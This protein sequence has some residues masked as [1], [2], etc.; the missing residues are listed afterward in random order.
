MATDA[1][2]LERMA[3]ESPDECFLK[4]SGILKLTCAIRHLESENKR[5]SAELE[6]LQTKCEQLRAELRDANTQIQEFIYPNNWDGS[7]TVGPG[8]GCITSN[9]YEP[10]STLRLRIDVIGDYWDEAQTDKVC[11][12][13]AGRLNNYQKLCA[14]LEALKAVE[15]VAYVR[16]GALY[17]RAGYASDADADLYTGPQLPQIMEGWKLVPIELA[18]SMLAACKGAAWMY[19][20]IAYKAMLEAAPQPEPHTPQTISSTGDQ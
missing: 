5:L 15:P 4:G 14:E 8:V 17:F 6:A 10:N 2:D 7:W 12:D 20:K 1:N 19:P 16:N 11:H 3:K 13:I 9:E 18:E